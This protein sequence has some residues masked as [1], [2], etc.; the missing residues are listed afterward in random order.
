MV[1]E[2]PSHL[3]GPVPLNMTINGQQYTTDTIIFNYYKID[4]LYPPRGPFPGETI[5]SVIGYGFVPTTKMLC[6]INNLSVPATYHA[7]DLLSCIAPP[8]ERHGNGTT[9]L[10]PQETNVQFE[11]A[12]DDEIDDAFTANGEA[13]FLFGD[14]E[15]TESGLRYMYYE[16]PTIAELSPILGPATGD[17]VVTVHGQRFLNTET[18]RCKFGDIPVVP[19]F[20]SDEILHCPSPANQAVLANVSISN[21]DQQ[22]CNVLLYEY[23]TPP[24]IQVLSPNN[25]PAV[26][27]LPNGTMQAEYQ[28]RVTVFGENFHAPLLQPDLAL[29]WCRFGD[30]IVVATLIDD[31]R[32]E[33]L[34]PLHEQAVV[35][36]EITLNGQQFSS[37]GVPFSF[38]GFR[39]VGSMAPLSGNSNPAGTEVHIFG[40]HFVDGPDVGCVFSGMAVQGYFVSPHDMFCYTPIFGSVF[41]TTLESQVEVPVVI[42][43]N[44]QQFYNVPTLFMYSDSE[45]G[46]SFAYPVDGSEMNG[47]V[48]SVAGDVGTFTIQASTPDGRH[49]VTGRDRFS[50]TFLG[51]QTLLLELRTISQMGIDQGGYIVD[52]NNGRYTAMY[53]VTLSGI[54]EM[55][56]KVAYEHIRDSPFEMLVEPAHTHTPN[57]NAFGSGLITTEAGVRSRLTIQARDRFNNTRAVW[58]VHADT[59]EI[60]AAPHEA[61]NSIRGLA[62]VFEANAPLTFSHGV[63]TNNFDGTYL[64][65]FGPLLVAGY[66]NLDVTSGIDHI[67][68]SPF[69]VE[70][71][72]SHS[73]SLRSYVS[74]PGIEAARAGYAAAATV[75]SVDIH[76]NLRWTGG[77]TL[78]VYLREFTRST[79]DITADVYDPD[80]GRYN[81]TY[82]ATFAGQYRLYIKIMEDGF[83]RQI[84][85][86]DLVDYWD[87]H[88]MPGEPYGPLSTVSGLG[89]DPWNGLDRGMAGVLNFINV[90]AFDEFGNRKTTGGD[91]TFTFSIAGPDSASGELIDLDDGHHLLQYNL[92]RSGNYSLS[93]SVFGMSTAGSPFNLEII[94]QSPSAIVCRPHSSPLY[95]QTTVAIEANFFDLHDFANYLAL[96][97]TRVVQVRL[98]DGIRDPYI[99][100]GTFLTDRAII[101]FVTPSYRAA[102]FLTVEIRAIGQDW[103][104]TGYQFQYYLP[105]EMSL[106]TPRAGPVTGNT[107]AI[108]A[109]RKFVETS[110]ATC[111]F[112][113]LTVPAVIVDRQHLEC[114][115]TAAS[116][117]Q[118]HT[119]A[120]QIALNGQQYTA[121]LVHFMYYAAPVIIQQQSPASGPVTGETEIY[122]TGSN[123]VETNIIECHF[124]FPDATVAGQ[125]YSDNVILC[126]SPRN[127]DGTGLSTVSIAL[128]GQQ[129]SAT[130]GQFLYYRVP[131]VTSVSPDYGSF[132]GGT[133]IVIAGNHFVETYEI[134]CRFGRPEHETDGRIMTV[135]S[136]ASIA[137]VTPDTLSNALTATIEISLNGQQ[138]TENGTA[139]HFVAEISSIDPLRGPASGGTVIAVTGAGFALV[140]GTDLLCRFGSNVVVL[141]H[142]NS[143]TR[144][145]CQSPPV[146]EEPLG[147]AFAVSADGGNYYSESDE[148]FHY[149]MTP[150]VTSLGL[151]YPSVSIM[152]G[153]FITIFG[154]NFIFSPELFV[155]FGFDDVLV[156]AA[157]TRSSTGS[158][159]ITCFS[160]NVRL[161]PR[162]PTDVS[163]EISMNGQQYTSDGAQLNMYN[164]SLPPLVH[165]IRPG[166]GRMEG[167]TKVNFYGYNFAN[168]PSLECKFAGKRYPDRLSATFVSSSLIFCYSPANFDVDGSTLVTGQQPV[169]VSNGNL[170]YGILW[171]QEPVQFRYTQTSPADSYAEGPGLQAFGE[172]PVIAGNVASFTIQAVRQDGVNR[173]TGGDT[174]YVDLQRQSNSV[175][176]LSYSYTAVV[177]DLDPD[178]QQQMLRDAEYDFTAAVRSITSANASLQQI[179]N[180]LDGANARGSYIV[181]QNVTVSGEY[182]MSVKVA[183]QHIIDSPF[184]IQVEYGSLSLPSCGVFGFGARESMAG[185]LS[186]LF[187]QARD[188]WGNNRTHETS[189]DRFDVS[190]SLCSRSS[191]ISCNTL[192]GNSDSTNVNVAITVDARIAGLTQYSYL[193]TTAGVYSLRASFS[194]LDVGRTPVHVPIRPAQTHVPSCRVIAFNRTVIAGEHSTIVVATYDQFR[195]SREIGGERILITL[196]GINESMQFVP[197][198]NADATYELQFNLTVSGDHT[199]HITVNL[200]HFA[201]SPLEFVVLPTTLLPSKCLPYGMGI[202]G[203]AVGLTNKFYIQAKDRF[204]NNRIDED[205]FFMARFTV[206]SELD[207]WRDPLPPINFTTRFLG[208]GLYLMEYEINVAGNYI[209]ETTYTENK[210]FPIIS[211]WLRINVEPA[212][213]HP[214]SC[215]TTGPGIHNTVAGQMTYILLQLR[216]RFQ[217]NQVEG[218]Q[219]SNITIEAIAKMPLPTFWNERP[220]LTP[221]T[222]DVKDVGFGLYNISYLIFPSMIYDIKV[223]FDGADAGLS[224]IQVRKL[225]APPPQI[226]LAKFDDSL[227]RITV[228]FDQETNQARMGSNG[229]CEQIIGS[230]LVATLGV[231]PLCMWKT[232]S[233]LSISLGYKST[234]TTTQAAALDDWDLHMTMLPNVLL[235]SYENSHPANNTVAILE[236]QHPPTPVAIIEASLMVGLCEPMVI[237]GT[238]SYGGGPRPLRFTWSELENPYQLVHSADSIPL[239]GYLAQVNSQNYNRFRQ[240]E[241]SIMQMVLGRND[242]E[243]GQSYNWSLKV[244]SFINKVGVAYW[245]VTKES[246]PLPNV[247]IRGGTE[248]TVLSQDEIIIQGDA[249][250]PNPE[251]IPPAWKRIAF[252][253]YIDAD[254][255]HITANAAKSRTLF[256]PPSSLQAYNRYVLNLTA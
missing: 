240:S 204:G 52:N 155:R 201:D 8:A 79:A 177:I 151:E 53:N 125:L 205:D 129:Y 109:G 136:V 27:N 112:G 84:A 15:Y 239:V 153:T 185:R 116:E 87:I 82:V 73:S 13:Q 172:G 69:V 198:D 25:G 137:C 226:V 80:T 208:M 60:Q 231:G 86:N 207:P 49:K 159:S 96:T 147:V 164:P 230:D 130:V 56:V 4:A 238:K 54:Y 127:A 2:S 35:P 184:N 241:S 138:F 236:P 162:F 193:T 234:I 134:R 220:D 1:C 128:N 59:F 144:I 255:V 30:T 219:L 149:Y 146:P 20:I 114:I 107:S 41:H 168:V 10:L 23:Y 148:Q 157:I 229:A 175:S 173:V 163:I 39:V 5:V 246:V 110:E 152:G 196:L 106:V 19:V 48:Q 182:I 247:F 165:E 211:G 154:T 123:F 121:S 104:E 169:S 210:D 29:L 18:L 248:L 176:P 37:N 256:L 51:R 141:A 22:Y 202:E 187:V 21:N 17:T 135:Q 150:S 192:H 88:V 16:N 74:G 145:T 62:N 43:T 14:L 61:S 143:S 214:P 126:V 12:G 103:S 31:R 71:H 105:P 46:L 90:Q 203:A 174:F 181:L 223:A 34:L 81:I 9:F 89:D 92:T 33:C 97:G 251:C 218:G 170:G 45:P 197:V 93:I 200:T 55:S 85:A 68:G 117:T 98:D 95:G 199:A 115:T 66:Y 94:P 108:I 77:D 253:W 178:V 75:T 250:L 76:G 38:Y 58:Q 40:S 194:G 191:L 47:L 42:T 216:D 232:R 122:F 183:G 32:V 188:K 249:S 83:M 180:L 235:S 72:P 233:Q 212:P 190:M 119:V 222:I 3:A 102:G 195:N 186:S 166:S 243:P 70:I 179:E 78:N 209:M 245:T 111:M 26:D 36:L 213:V 171:S 227:I 67:H 118:T 6:L 161:D 244:Q 158:S 215:L 206:D 167:S 237:T 224:P 99:L 217:N 57:C 120:L 100:M 160:P 140:D 50:V 132:R 252:R 242:T 24:Q 131:S 113:N 63:V 28:T 156:N 142:F 101:E 11:I 91:G 189:A 139:F 7:I 221:V 228:V 64:G 225:L 65:R 254:D 44:Q 133:E 124:S